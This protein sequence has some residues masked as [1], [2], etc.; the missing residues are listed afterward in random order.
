MERT[1]WMRLGV[2]L[3]ITE[4]E[5]AV[6]FGDDECKAREAIARIVAENR[7]MPDG[8]SY[9]PSEAVEDFN[10]RYGTGHEVDDIGVDF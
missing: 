5:E 7:F 3:R 4:A 10:Q 1:L 8:E 9:V 2:T 6:L